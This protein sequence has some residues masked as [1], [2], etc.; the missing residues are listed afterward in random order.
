MYMAVLKIYTV[1]SAKPK[2]YLFYFR[3]LHYVTVECEY[4]F[5]VKIFL[6]QNTK[7]LLVDPNIS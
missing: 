6:S 2:L 7:A 4:K 1:A 5:W 3:N